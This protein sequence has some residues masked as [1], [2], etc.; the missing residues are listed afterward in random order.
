M[1]LATRV[2]YEFGKYR[3][4]P[5]EHLL[6]CD[7]KPVAL[8]PKAFDILCVF[9]QNSGRLLSKDELMKRVWPNSFVEEANLSVNISALR[10]ALGDTP[11]GQ[12]LI[13]TVPKMGY[14]FVMPVRE[15]RDPSPARG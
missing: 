10:R 9:A 11:D 4:D 12:E 13:A 8:T 5:A 2:L 1:T 7:G 3:L 14:R 15:I 6:L